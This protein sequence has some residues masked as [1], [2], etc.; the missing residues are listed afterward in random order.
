MELSVYALVPALASPDDNDDAAHS[1]RHANHDRRY[2]PGN[3]RHAGGPH[4]FGERG[5][6][7][8]RFGYFYYG[9]GPGGC[10]TDYPSPPDRRAYAAPLA[11][12]T[13]PGSV[14]FGPYRVRV[15]V[16]RMVPTRGDGTWLGSGL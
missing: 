11:R 4:N 9:K 5:V 10:P 6:C 2:L 16:L 12:A 1:L 15:P 3:S 14:R 8:P 13:L 7:P